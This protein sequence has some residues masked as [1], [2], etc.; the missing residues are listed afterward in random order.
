MSRANIVVEPQAQKPATS[1]EPAQKQAQAPADPLGALVVPQDLADIDPTYRGK[2]VRDIITMHQHSTKK[3]GELGNEIGVW[4]NLVSD[5]SSRAPSAPAQGK[6]AEPVKITNEELLADPTK[7]ISTV[8]K[9]VLTDHLKPLEEK[10]GAQAL[11]SE[12][13][14]LRQ[15]YPNML[16][17]GND[18]QFLEWAQGSRS[19]QADANAA[20]RGDAGAARRLLEN[21]NDRQQ[22]V[23]SLK[24]AGAGAGSSKPGV[25]AARRAV[26]ETG[27][28]GGAA[29][30]KSI[31]AQEVINTIMNEPEKYRSESYQ[32]DLKAAIAAGQLRM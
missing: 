25:E 17:V 30:T 9:D 7:A 15:E 16:E 23:A 12:F 29:P 28:A 19:R 6:P 5:I 4:K 11:Q 20:Q 13:A 26:T 14:A 22:L 24:D 18:P 3:I 2:S 32:N 1:A 31:T 21:W 10:L 27:G 8:L